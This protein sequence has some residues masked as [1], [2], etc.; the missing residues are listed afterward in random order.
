MLGM[1]EKRTEKGEKRREKEK[2]L[3]LSPFSLLCFF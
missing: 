1:G 2:L 3:S